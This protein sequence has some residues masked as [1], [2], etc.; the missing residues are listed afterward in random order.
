LVVDGL[1]PDGIQRA[2]T[3]QLHLLMKVR[4]STLHAHA[5]MSTVSSAN[6]ALVIMEAG[7]EQH[8]ITTNNWDLDKFEIRPTAVGSGGTFPTIHL[9]LVDGAGHDH[10][11]GTLQ[12]YQAIAEANRLVGL[13]LQGLKDASVAKSTIV[14]ITIDHGGKGKGHGGVI[15][16]QIEIAWILVDPGV[17]T[18]KELTTHVNT[19]DTVATVAYVVGRKTLKC[20]IARPVLEAFAIDAARQ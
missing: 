5:V 20:W 1:S 13:I 8:T 19:Y 18:G 12:Y 10:G 14:L 17:A 15:M 11:H 16:G 4:A 6:W 7:L 3:P 2:A 9:D